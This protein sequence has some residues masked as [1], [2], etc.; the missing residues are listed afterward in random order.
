[1]R[2]WKVYP[3]K[4]DK[5]KAARAWRKVAQN[6]GADAIIAGAKAYRD[7]A[8]RVDGYTKY[9]ATWLNAAG[10]EDEDS[11]PARYDPRLIPA[12]RQQSPEE[13]RAEI[14]ALI[15]GTE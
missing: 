3:L 11:L 9:P 15:A 6:V 10:W 8:N 2:F 5:G 13:I 7:D 1:L 12:P 4:R 14:E